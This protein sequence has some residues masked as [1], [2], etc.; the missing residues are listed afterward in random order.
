ME[1]APLYK[2]FTLNLQGKCTNCTRGVQGYHLLMISGDPEKL[3]SSCY[4]RTTQFP[5]TNSLA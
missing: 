1:F 3:L 2:V 4:P 5:Y